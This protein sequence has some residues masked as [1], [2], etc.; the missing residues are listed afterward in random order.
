MVRLAVREV[1]CRIVLSG[2]S[3]TIGRGGCGLNQHKDY[4]TIQVQIVKVS[5]R[6][7]SCKRRKSYAK[8]NYPRLVSVNIHEGPSACGSRPLS[9][10][11]G[12][13]DRQNAGQGADR[14]VENPFGD[15]DQ[16][17]FIRQVRAGRGGP[18]EDNVVPMRPPTPPA[19]GSVGDAGWADDYPRMTPVDELPDDRVEPGRSAPASRFAGASV[20]RSG[21]SVRGVILGM[22]A[23]FA[24]VLLAFAAG[25]AF[26]EILRSRAAAPVTA[27]PPAVVPAPL[28]TPERATAPRVAPVEKT[29]PERAPV[30]APVERQIAAEPPVAVAPK[31][32]A[33]SPVIAKPVVVPRYDKRP[34]TAARRPLPEKRVTTATRAP[35][36]RAS[37]AA[38]ADPAEAPRAAAKPLDLLA[39]AAPV[40]GAAEGPRDDGDEREAGN[41]RPKAKAK[42]PR[43]VG[44][45]V[46]RPNVACRVG[47]PR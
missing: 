31:H 36:S 28:P 34:A 11:P 25:W 7:C 10:K 14:R 15:D 32:R 2:G 29:V 30:V 45:Q 42:L 44:F 3:W 18:E 22:V 4:I 43:C 46:Y 35:E 16:P 38:P 13:N 19:D 5:P 41:E 40:A 47:G 1:F 39:E 9:T 33:A 27:T 21:Q 26:N 12:P 8:R 20:A 37:E 17:W 24:I 6:R 23:G